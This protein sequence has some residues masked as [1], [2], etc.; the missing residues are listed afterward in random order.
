[1]PTWP[2]YVSVADADTYHASHGSP[3]AWTGAT[4]STKELSLRMATEWLDQTY[5][6]RWN[7]Y[8]TTST[9]QR[10][11]P[12]NGVYDR[13]DRAFS[14]TE[15]PQVVKDATCYMALRY[16]QGGE[17]RPDLSY[18]GDIKREVSKVGPLETEVEYVGGK[19]QDKV[20]RVVDDMLMARG[21][22]ASGSEAFRA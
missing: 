19:S 10:D 15:V 1:M 8:R 4:T 14:S 7:G 22:I 5:G 12:R 3:A 20:Y 9:Q 2:A 17:L 18:S 11:W 13:D 6:T 16:V 21:V